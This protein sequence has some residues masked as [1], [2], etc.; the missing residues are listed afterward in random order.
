[1]W[2]LPREHRCSGEECHPGW[3]RQQGEP[4]DQADPAE[5]VPLGEEESCER[6]REEQCLAVDGREEEARREEREVEHCS[7]R[8]RHAQLR[9]SQAMKEHER[10]RCGC[11]R[12]EDTRN[13]VVPGQR[14]T[15]DRD[16]QWIER[17]ERGGAGRPG[18]AL[19]RD[20]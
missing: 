10:C 15:G 14:S 6:E 3:A 4:H 5:A 11:R 18:V 7:P 1:M 13:Q 9:K 2:G 8:A 17:E 12:D 19:R 20:P 16:E